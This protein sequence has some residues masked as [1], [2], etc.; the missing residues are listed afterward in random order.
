MKYV[1]EV[2]FCLGAC[3]I[4]NSDGEYIGKKSTAF[5]YNIKTIDSIKIGTKHANKNMRECNP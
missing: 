5:T 4:K 1:Y 3:V 2:R